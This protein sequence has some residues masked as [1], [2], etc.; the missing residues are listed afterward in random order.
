LNGAATIAGGP[1]VDPITEG[2]LPAGFAANLARSHEIT[3][4]SRL[5]PPGVGFGRSNRALAVG[6]IDGDGTADVV[7]GFAECAFGDCDAQGGAVRVGVVRAF[8][9]ATGEMLVEI[10][11]SPWTTPAQIDAFGAE[12]ALADVNAD[13]RM[14][15]V[16]AA[17][18]ANSNRGRVDVFDST[19]E[20][21]RSV[22]GPANAVRFGSSLF[23]LGDAT[24]DLNDDFLVLDNS[25]GGRFPTLWSINGSTGAVLHSRVVLSD[26]INLLGDRDRDGIPEYACGAPDFGAPPE[27]ARA[28]RG[29]TGAV[30]FGYNAAEGFL[31]WL[32]DIDNDGFDEFVQFI[33]IFEF[34][35]PGVYVNEGSAGFPLSPPPMVIKD[36]A[37]LNGDGV[38]DASMINGGPLGAFDPLDDELNVL[39]AQARQPGARFLPRHRA[40]V[41]GEWLRHEMRS[42]VYGDIVMTTPRNADDIAIEVYPVDAKGEDADSGRDR[43]VVAVYAGPWLLGDA[44]A[45]GV[46]N[47]T[48]LNMVLARYNRY[49]DADRSGDVN[50]DGAVNEDDLLAVLDSFGAVGPTVV[51][52]GK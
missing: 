17:P 37:D 31:S 51:P 52:P 6:D 11:G 28:M 15:F 21:L 20:F 23:R 45:D 22:D 34:R 13:G 18:L 36:A 9:G 29:D 41:G 42:A 48:D 16:I 3:L 1:E 35:S 47:F 43:F 7:M 5:T 46:V 10:L 49:S 44:N 12:V 50:G 4:S 25:D 24:R 2:L 38:L 32:G 19:G 8:S 39:D 40:L 27:R 30:Q 14:D 33:A 26:R